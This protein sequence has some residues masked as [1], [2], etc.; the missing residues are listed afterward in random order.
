M[1]QILNKTDKQILNVYN[2]TQRKWH[3]SFLVVFSR[4]VVVI[5]VRRL[6]RWF[7]EAGWRVAGVLQ[8]L[9]SLNQT[10]EVS[11]GSLIWRWVSFFVMQP[12]TTSLNMSILTISKLKILH[13]KYSS[14]KV[15]FFC[16]NNDT[17]PQDVKHLSMYLF[18]RDLTPTSPLQ[19]LLS[20][21][22]IIVGISV[23]KTVQLYNIL[24]YCTRSSF[25]VSRIVL[26][27]GRS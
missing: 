25:T 10:T 5:V 15:T 22:I 8:I 18:W 20:T 7:L 24:L 19:H 2:S 1:I 9:D 4:V 26:V 27:N 21:T 17:C 3:Q 23:S 12:L 16:W 6:H 13:Y 11:I 14:F